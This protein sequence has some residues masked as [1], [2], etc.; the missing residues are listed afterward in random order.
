MKINHLLLEKKPAII[1]KW[2][3]SILKTYPAETANFLKSHNNRFSNPVGHTISRGIEGLFEEL[4]QGMDSD[5]VA[6]YLDKII[7]IRALQELT[8]SKAL[9]F[10]FI[11]KKVIREEL[12]KE[13]REHDLFKELMILESKVDDIANISF[14]IFMECREKLYELKAR[15]AR[16]L[17]IR[18]LKRMNMLEESRAVKESAAGL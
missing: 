9:G 11:L 15:E 8:P 12:A 13:I 16:N 3:D 5:R 17:T 1:K 18:I 6:L 4:L 7:R 14:D 10:I 2:F